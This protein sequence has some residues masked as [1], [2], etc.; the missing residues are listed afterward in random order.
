LGKESRK[1]ASQPPKPVLTNKGGQDAPSPVVDRRALEKTMSDLRRVLAG[2]DFADI[3]EANRFIA[4]LMTTTGG[5]IPAGGALTPLEEAQDLMYEAWDAKG[6]ARTRLARKALEMSPDCADAY[7]L[8]AEESA[9]NVE[10]ARDLFAQGLAAGER[11]LGPEF[12][13]EEAG[14]FWGILE[15]RPYMRAREGL[16]ERLWRLGERE[17][18]IEHYREMLRLNPNDNQGVRYVLLDCLLGMGRNDEAGELLSRYEDD[19]S[20]E[21]LYNHALWL[22]RR[23]G[24]SPN[25]ARSIKEALAENKHVP[26]YLLGR[27]RIPSRLPDTLAFGGDDEAVDYVIHALSNW[28]STSGAL[29]WLAAEVPAIGKRRGQAG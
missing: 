29:T 16:A 20:A 10:E 7:V 4:D 22:F 18:A 17:A 9:R 21:W 11:G 19:G 25:A 8:L 2:Q 5:R 12:F 28:M 14:H 3:D 6:V 26:A 13:E 1:K 27:K 23:E 15:T 24:G